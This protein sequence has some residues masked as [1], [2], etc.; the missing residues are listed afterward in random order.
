[1]AGLVGSI[2]NIVIRTDSS[3]WIGSGHLMRCLNLAESLT[4]KGTMVSF[5]S[6]KLP[7]NLNHLILKKG[8]QVNEM[9]QTTTT[10]DDLSNRLYN[11][12]D[13]RARLGVSEKQDAFETIN[14]IYGIKPDWLIMDHYSLGEKWE[15][16]IRPHVKKIMVIDDLANRSHDC[17]L[18]LDQNWF[19]NMET[20][21]D[22]LVPA[23][24]T[25]LFGPKYVLLGP[26][27]ASAREKIKHH[28]DDVKR[29][30]IYF[31]GSDPHNL[32]GMALQAVSVPELNNLEVDVVIGENNPHKDVLF[33]LV[34]ALDNTHLHIQ[35]DDMATIMSKADLAI[36][37]GGVN[38]WERMCLGLP[39]LTI[40]FAENH[41]MLL[42]D[43]SK[44][45]YVTYLGFSADVDIE[46][47]KKNLIEQ[48]TDVPSFSNL[49]KKLYD[50]VNGNG[51]KS[52]VD[53][54]TGNFV[55]NKWIVK[56]ATAQDKKLYWNWANDEQVRKN[57]INKNYITWDNHIKWFNNKL[58]D[59]KCFL[60]I[61][62]Y[63]RKPVGQVRFE[64]EGDF[65]RIDY[66]ISRQF[67]GRR[68][69]KKLLD[70]A[71]KEFKKYSNQII[72]G[73]VLAENIASTK[74]FESLGFSMEIK[75][76][77]KIYTKS[78]NK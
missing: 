35:V 47:I 48:I 6:R 53:W 16:I 11:I 72:L 12:D 10:S 62:L 75:G 24:C 1:V 66:S 74:T 8:F 61:I 54:L 18:L 44:N 57:S 7:G 45:G 30:F 29:L 78:I 49:R 41:T 71:I 21:Y 67:R 59:P 58:A 55:D 4:K 68:L 76:V 70:R 37:S 65:A 46:L 73:E 56:S 26:E 22:H 28:N 5:V 14:L 25:K 31:G 27:F 51:V 50:L 69:G 43:L 60:Y 15:K 40:S 17:D 63:D 39:A 64:N 38:T 2:L 9:P 42:K 36:G 32:T 77:N 20:R 3:S 34:E 33:K 23:G 13:Y 52:V 19:E